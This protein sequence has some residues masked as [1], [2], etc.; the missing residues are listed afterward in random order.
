MGAILVKQ[1]ALKRGWRTSPRGG[2]GR[3][4]PS[5]TTGKLNRA[6]FGTDIHVGELKPR[7][8]TDAGSY[9]VPVSIPVH[10]GAGR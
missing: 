2:E 3:L 10:G 4:F 5:A 8:P 7:T 1:V 9:Q 6:A